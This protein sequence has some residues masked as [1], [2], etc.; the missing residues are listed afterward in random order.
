PRVVRLTP[1][2][3]TK[4]NFGAAISRVVRIDLADRAFGNDEDSRKPRVELMEGLEAL[5]AQIA[6]TPTML[7]LSYQLEKG[8]SDAIA[9]Q[10]MNVVERILRKLWPANGRYQ[11]NVEQVIQR[12]VPK[13]VNE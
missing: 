8:E 6:D 4:M 11:L 12:W 10:R 5:V 7:R 2:M 9:R 3:L 1:G 13:A